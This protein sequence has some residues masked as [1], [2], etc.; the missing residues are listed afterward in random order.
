MGAGQRSWA[1]VVLPSAA[2]HLSMPF[3]LFSSSMWLSFSRRY[4]KPSLQRD[5]GAELSPGPRCLLCISYV[6]GERSRKKYFRQN[7]GC[8]LRRRLRKL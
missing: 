5:T 4:V 8:K 2:P 6:W 3:S 7:R 1:G